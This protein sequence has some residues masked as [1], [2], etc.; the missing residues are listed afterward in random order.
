MSGLPG[1]ESE[2]GGKKG[3]TRASQGGYRLMHG[4]VSRGDEV[5]VLGEG[6]SIA[7][8][9]KRSRAEWR[10]EELVERGI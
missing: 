5:G 10:L 8:Y 4:E 1:L 2:S 7:M 3:K 9:E 6:W